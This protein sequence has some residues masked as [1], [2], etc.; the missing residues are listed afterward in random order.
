MDK[1]V[2]ILLAAL[3]EFIGGALLAVATWFLRDR[4][5]LIKRFG[6]FIVLAVIAFG[7]GFGIGRVNNVEQPQ[8]SLVSLSYQLN[9]IDPKVV[10]L[11]TV[12]T[13]GITVRINDRLSLTDLW[14]S[15][16]QDLD[17]FINAEVYVGSQFIGACSNTVSV[18][19]GTH[20]I[21]D[22]K[23]DP[24]FA[25]QDNPNAW[26][27]RDGWISVNVVPVLYNNEGEKTNVLKSL[28][29]ALSD[30]GSNG[31]VN[32]LLQEQICD[33]IVANSLPE[34][35]EIAA[36]TNE[37]VFEGVTFELRASPNTDMRILFHSVKLIVNN[38]VIEFG[39]GF[40]YQD[41]VVSDRQMTQLNGAVRVTTDNVN[42]L[43]EIGET[44]MTHRIT[45]HLVS[46]KGIHCESPID[47]LVKIVEP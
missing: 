30:D 21:G 11:R 23:P 14:Y 28:T 39:Q 3:P 38:Q 22:C 15:S 26:E 40:D 8:I 37:P 16:E 2:D 24:N 34:L 35:V 20:A 32:A 5:E 42:K 46:D 4:I 44:L 43:K 31:L 45:F 25:S 29:I 7:V 13:E 18:R 47:T 36:P 1:L 12:G 10:D 33:G 6:P 27:I 41:E 19:S 17:R 9:E